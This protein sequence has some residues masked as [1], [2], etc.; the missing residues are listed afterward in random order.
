MRIIKE[1]KIIKEDTNGSDRLFDIIIDA[2]NY[3]K[4]FEINDLKIDKRN[5]VITFTTDYPKQVRNAIEWLAEYHGHVTFKFISKNT[6]YLYNIA[7][8]K[9]TISKNTSFKESNQYGFKDVMTEVVGQESINKFM[10]QFKIG[11]QEELEHSA[12]LEDNV[13]SIA[14]VVLDHLEEDIEY[15]TKLKSIMKEKHENT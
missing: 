10:E 15:Y 4:R 13:V 2:I 7:Q 8:N 6:K 3:I 5:E 1:G 14:K 12:T 11:F 9:V